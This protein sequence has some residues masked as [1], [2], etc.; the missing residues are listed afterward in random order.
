MK[1]ESYCEGAK[2]ELSGEAQKSWLGVGDGKCG[3]NEPNV[4]G[5][6]AS[7]AARGRR[8]DTV[9]VRGNWHG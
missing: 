5:Y 3:R 1:S 2:I 6:P 4:E 9:P 7:G 8:M